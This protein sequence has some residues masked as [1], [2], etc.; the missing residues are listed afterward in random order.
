M[1]PARSA[2]DG[3]RVSRRR[4][5]PSSAGSAL[6]AVKNVV[7]RNES[8]QSQGIAGCTVTTATAEREHDPPSPRLRRAGQAN[9]QLTTVNRRPAGIDALGAR[10]YRTG[11]G[12]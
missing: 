12:R 7:P 10:R 9:R 4:R 3:R 11:G 5:V 1:T 8:K 2:G 6:S